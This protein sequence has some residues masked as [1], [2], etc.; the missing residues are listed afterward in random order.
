MSSL[1]ERN[2]TI[3]GQIS[4][5]YKKSLVYQEKIARM[6]SVL[7]SGEEKECGSGKDKRSVDEGYSMVKNNSLRKS[8]VISKRKSSLNFEKNSKIL[9]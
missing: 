3:S 1:L 4:T 7:S 2:K 6:G 8:F 5:Y 9:T